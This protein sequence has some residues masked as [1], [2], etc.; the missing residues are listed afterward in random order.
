MRERSHLPLAFLREAREYAIGVHGN[1]VAH[2]FEHRNVGRAVG[3][4][5]GVL[6]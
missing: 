1:G 4:R 3:V 6:E 2:D 5:I